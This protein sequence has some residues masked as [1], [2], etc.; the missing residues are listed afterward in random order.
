MPLIVVGS[1]SSVSSQN[2]AKVK[3]PPNA[4]TIASARV[5]S[6]ADCCA[7]CRIRFEIVSVKF[8]F[9]GVAMIASCPNCAVVAEWPA[10]KPDILDRLRKFGASCFEPLGR[11]I[12]S[13]DPL[14]FRLRYFVEILFVTVIIAGLLRHVFHVYGGF[15]R[16]EIRAGALMVIPVV[17]L[18]I[19]FFQRKRHH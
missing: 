8:K 19:M 16:E 1:S 14:S 12:G 2:T 5:L 18:A 7:N 9:G 17:T 13:V 6:E 3:E 10:A 4:K 11:A 15:S